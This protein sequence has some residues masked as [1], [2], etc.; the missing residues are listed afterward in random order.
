[1]QRH[2]CHCSRTLLRTFT[3][4]NEST[5]KQQNYFYASTC[6]REVRSLAYLLGAL[7]GPIRGRRARLLLSAVHTHPSDESACKSPH[8]Q[9]SNPDVTAIGERPKMVAQR[10]ARPSAAT[11]AT[12]TITRTALQ[13]TSKEGPVVAETSAEHQHDAQVQAAGKVPRHALVWPF[14]AAI[15]RR[16]ANP[17]AVS[18]QQAMKRWMEEE[19]VQSVV[20]V[21]V[22]LPVLPFCRGGGGLGSGARQSRAVQSSYSSSSSSSKVTPYFSAIAAY[23]SSSLDW[24]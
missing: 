6:C 24:R 16:C 15:H 20:A 21:A 11:T 7:P 22:N 8:R 2:A 19:R 17:T 18:A 23:S 14:S 3:R 10:R 9:T 12:P 4:T 1:M 13:N 5:N